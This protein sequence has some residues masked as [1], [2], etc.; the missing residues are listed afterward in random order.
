MPSKVL[1]FRTPLLALSSHTSLPIVLMLPPRIF[2]CVAFVHLHKNQQT[3][4]DPCAVRCLFLGYALY[5]KGYRCFDPITKRT[6]ITMDV[7]FLEMETF[8]PSPATKSSLQGEFPNEEVNWLAKTWLESERVTEQPNDENTEVRLTEEHPLAEEP[9]VEKPC[10]MERNETPAPV[11]DMTLD[12]TT[13]DG[14][15]SLVPED[16][17]HKNIVEV[18]L[19]AISSFTNNVNSTMQYVLPVRQNCGKPP[20]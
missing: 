17:S 1:Q 15:P 2:G 18:S 8:Y 12:A 6:Y 7:T 4:L 11:N 10:N 13:S 19:L 9:T 3:K 20:S 14:S 16:P 5:Q